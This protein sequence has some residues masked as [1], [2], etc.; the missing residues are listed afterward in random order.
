MR[1]RIS[2]VAI[3]VSLACVS[4]ALAKDFT[5]AAD[6]SGDFKTV[7][8]A[9]DAVPANNTSPVTISVKPG[10]YEEYL[11]ITK[12]KNFITLVGGGDTPDKTVLTF[13]YKASDPKPDGTGTVGTTG[14]SST[15]VNANDFTAENVTFENSAGDNVGQ[16]VAL[17]TNG[18]RLIFRNCRFTGFQDT[19][20]PAGKGRVYF[21]DCYI[22]GDTDFSFGNAT[23]V[24]DHCTINSTDRGWVTAA[25][26]APDTAAGYVFLDCT[27]TAGP[28]V[29]PGAVY[30]G[31]PWQWQN[32]KPAVTFVR[33]KMG[34]HINPAGWHPWDEKA[35]TSPGEH[36][37]YAEFGSMDQAGKPLDVS[38]RVAW[39]HQLSADEASKLTPEALLAGADHWNPLAGPSVTPSTK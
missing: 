12:G 36:S 37:R 6:G 25:N 39:S 32:T 27:L 13:H 24:F 3:T 2:F 30:L 22:T 14:S 18:D 21:K 20:Y 11:N 4:P 28:N 38:R 26:T 7:Q 17:K 23:A 16:A 15:T 8:A 19:L 29:P 31:R 10:R 33:T 1:H 35:N 34:P 5:V 9:V